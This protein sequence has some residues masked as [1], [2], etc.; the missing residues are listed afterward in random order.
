[1]RHGHADLL[2]PGLRAGG[3]TLLIWVTRPAPQVAEGPGGRSARV[4]GHEH[5]LLIIVGDGQHVTVDAYRPDPGMSERL[6]TE[7]GR[8]YRVGGPHLHK[9]LAAG[10]QLGQ[11]AGEPYVTG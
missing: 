10:P 8:A 7:P 11:Q 1:M 2:V 4:R 9:L 3:M 5:H 6:R